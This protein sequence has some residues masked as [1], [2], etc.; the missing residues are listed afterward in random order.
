MHYTTGQIVRT[1]PTAN[2]SFSIYKIEGFVLD[3][4]KC[5]EICFLAGFDTFASE[6]DFLYPNQIELY[7]YEH[8]DGKYCLGDQVC[9]EGLNGSYV[10]VYFFQTATNEINVLLIPSEKYV[11]G[12]FDDGDRI[13]WSA[14]FCKKV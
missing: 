4:L 11:T 14:Q 5:C 3:T 6:S 12:K 1:H 8:S 2:G 9:V 10:P 7:E 13:N